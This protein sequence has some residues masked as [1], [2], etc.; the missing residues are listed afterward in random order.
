MLIFPRQKIQSGNTFSLALV[1]VNAG[2][3]VVDGAELPQNGTASS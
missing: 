1:A 3:E 2:R